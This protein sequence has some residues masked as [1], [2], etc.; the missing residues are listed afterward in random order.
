MQPYNLTTLQ[1]YNH[2]TIQIQIQIQKR[3][4]SVTPPS[5][6]SSFLLFIFFATNTL[7]TTF[8]LMR[9]THFPSSHSHGVVFQNLQLIFINFSWP[10]FHHGKHLTNFVIQ[11]PHQYIHH[12]FHRPHH[13]DQ[14]LSAN[15]HGGDLVANYPYDESRGDRWFFLFRISLQNSILFIYDSTR[16]S[17]FATW[18]LYISVFFLARFKKDLFLFAKLFCLTTRWV[19]TSC[20]KSP[21]HMDCQQFLIFCNWSFW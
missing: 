3:R 21:I 4:P 18:F 12:S 5:I 17:L 20:L 15:M 16:I 8:N 1:V 2:T 7:S 14:Q 13:S 10:E 19:L 11:N 9:V 6:N